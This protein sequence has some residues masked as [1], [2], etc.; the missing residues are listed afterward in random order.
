MV[1]LNSSLME[2]KV[3]AAKRGSNHF[4]LN[5]NLAGSSEMVQLDAS[6]TI[7]VLDLRGGEEV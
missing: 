6:L 5:L 3:Y 1:W 7:I 2:W 4:R